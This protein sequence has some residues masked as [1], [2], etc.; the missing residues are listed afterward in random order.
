MIDCKK[1]IFLKSI[2]TNNEMF[3]KGI[4]GAL[5]LT[6]FPKTGTNIPIKISDIKIK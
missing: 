2:V 1:L 6:I 5:Y 4:S 3:N